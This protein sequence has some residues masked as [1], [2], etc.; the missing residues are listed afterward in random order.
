MH[1]K[2]K[3]NKVRR[4]K[5][6]KFL[7][8]FLFFAFPLLFSFHFLFPFISWS[9]HWAWCSFSLLYFVFPF[10]NQ[11]LIYSRSEKLRHIHRWLT[12][13]EFWQGGARGLRWWLGEFGAGGFQQWWL[14]DMVI[15][16]CLLRRGS[17]EVDDLGSAR[18][19]GCH[20][21]GYFGFGNR[22]RWRVLGVI[23]NGR[24]GLASEG[25]VG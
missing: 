8:S 12:R 3:K 4:N 22:V 5:N 15:F 9:T 10:P 18:Q 1:N 23:G 13:A 25:T 2:E 6:C 16:G 14:A 21:G 17:S 19:C 11:N 7:S 20:S 24:M